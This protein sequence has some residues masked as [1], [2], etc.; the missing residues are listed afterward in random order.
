MTL[1]EII[2]CI[3]EVKEDYWED[4]G[5]GYATAD[6]QRITTALDEVM[7]RLEQTRWIPVSD[8]L[9]EP[10]MY[11][12]ATCRSLVDDRENWVVETIYLPILY[13]ISLKKLFNNFISSSVISYSLS[14]IL[15]V[16]KTISGLIRSISFFNFSISLLVIVLPYNKSVKCNTFTPLK[17]SGILISFITYSSISHSFDLLN[18][19]I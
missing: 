9:P 15:P 4:D 1:D 10:F 17:V 18:F 19:A 7:E 13:G 3:K 2:E 12:N 6:C 16:K 8:K 14:R 11:V 5:Y